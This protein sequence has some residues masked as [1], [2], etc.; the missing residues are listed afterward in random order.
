MR[1]HRN[2]LREI[3]DKN[4]DP[5]VAYVASKGHLKEKELEETPK[6]KE[7]SQEKDEQV[8]NETT[9]KVV[10]ENIDQKK[11]KK[12]PP[13]RKKKESSTDE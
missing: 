3:A 11:T 13:P 8:L 5:K 7:V 1:S 2:I 10:E 12:S 6:V 4:L 9:D